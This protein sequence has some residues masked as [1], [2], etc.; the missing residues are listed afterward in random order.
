MLQCK[1]D[2]N[3]GFVGHALVKATETVDGSFSRSLS[4][5]EDPPRRKVVEAML[6]E[7][8]NQTEYLVGIQAK[9]REVSGQAS[10]PAWRER[11]Q[12]LLELL[13]KMVR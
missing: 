2:A 12:I 10:D 11:I 13:R 1:K 6:K 5:R 9:C 3:K 4:G 7:S 8:S